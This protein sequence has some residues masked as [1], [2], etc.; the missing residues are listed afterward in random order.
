MKDRV[1]NRDCQHSCTFVF[2]MAALNENVLSP[3]TSASH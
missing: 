2:I 3:N 1:D